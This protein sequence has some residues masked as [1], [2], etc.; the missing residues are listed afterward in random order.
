MDLCCC[1]II[2]KWG[3]LRCFS[4][5]CVMMSGCCC[6]WLFYVVCWFGCMLVLLF[7]CYCVCLVV[8][9]LL[10]WFVV[11]RWWCFIVGLI[12]VWL[13]VWLVVAFWFG[14]VFSCIVL[15]LFWFSWVFVVWFD[16]LCALRCSFGLILVVFVVAWICLLVDLGMF[17]WLLFVGGCFNLLWFVVIWLVEFVRLLNCLFVG[18]VVNL[19]VDVWVVLV[20]AWLFLVLAFMIV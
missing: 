16:V 12:W 18:Y 11:C 9:W 8:R 19:F 15:V 1:L 10:F 7:D 4:I 5:G 14:C 17:S 3:W 2:T 6:V 20:V 13:F